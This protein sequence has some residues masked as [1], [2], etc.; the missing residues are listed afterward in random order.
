MKISRG[1]TYHAFDDKVYVHNVKSQRDYILN[2][3]ALEVLEFLA[4][5][6]DVTLESLLSKLSEEYEVDSKEIKRDIQE[7]IIEM[8]KEKIL[9][10]N[11]IFCEEN[12]WSNQIFMEVSRN[13]IENHKLFSISLELTWRCV[14]KCIHC[15]IGDVSKIS[16]NNELTI[17][18]Y[19]RILQQSHE[20]GCVHLLLTGGEV[21]L[22]SDLC[23]I[24]EYA[25]ELGFIVDIYTTGIG[26]TDEVFDRLCETTVNSISVSLYS[27]IAVEHDKITGLTGSFE[28]TLKFALMLK[29]AGVNTFIKCV[30]MKQNFNSLES[31]YKLC[32]RLKFD[33]K[34][35]P[36]VISKHR[37]KFIE[38]CSLDDIELYKKFFA[39][40]S[41]YIVE[42]DIVE[43]LSREQILNGITCSAGLNSLSI[44][45]FGNVRT[46]MVFKKSFGSIRENN[47]NTIWERTRNMK[48]KNLVLRKVT[49]KC[50]SCQYLNYCQVCVA[51]LTLEKGKNFTDCGETLLRAQAVA[52]ITNS[53][54]NDFN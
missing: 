4:R 40:N 14:E 32:K 15:Y 33:L 12:L 34:V 41:K 25:V 52:E 54:N 37:G 9:Y 50:E 24:V 48:L 23:D 45:P 43:E 36:L 5:N 18:E 7:F 27:G 39:L 38:N 46:C 2:G 6:N 16:I 17:D 11:E 44:D 42:N 10:E 35:T 1:V 13:F 51:A 31:L 49:P 53:T 26:I 29:S 3:I 22:R 19:K 47:L 8:I 21:L 20:L 28:K 30:A